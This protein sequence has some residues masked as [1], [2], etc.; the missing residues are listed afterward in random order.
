MK[1]TDPEV[2]MR[3]ER[4][5]MDGIIADLDWVLIEKIFKER[6]RLNIEDDVEYQQGNMIVHDNTIAYEL[7][8]QVKLNL[9]ILC[10]R[11]GNYIDVKSS[12]DIPEE[13]RPEN[14]TD[15]AKSD[16][17]PAPSDAMEQKIS[18]SVTDEDADEMIM[19]VTDTVPEQK[20]TPESELTEPDTPEDDSEIIDAEP[21]TPED[22][23]EITDAEPE[24]PEDD[25]EITDAEPETP[26]DDSEITDAEPEV[27]D[28]EPEDVVD[29]EPEVEID[30][31][32]SAKQLSDET[33]AIESQ[34]KVDEIKPEIMALEEYT[35]EKSEEIAPASAE[36]SDE[37]TDDTE[38]SHEPD[39]PQIDESETIPEEPEESIDDDISE[40][41]IDEEI[42]EDTDQPID[43]DITDEAIDADITDEAIDADI[44]DEAIDED[45]TDEAIDEEISEDLIAEDSIDEDSIDE[46]ISEEVKDE[47]EETD[48]VSDDISESEII[49]QEEDMS[50]DE[51]IDTLPIDDTDEDN[52]VETTD[53]VGSE[54]A[55]LDAEPAE[56]EMPRH[57]EDENEEDVEI[58][59]DD[60]IFESVS[61]KAAD[62][63]ASDEKAAD[64]KAQDSK[65]HQVSGSGFADWTEALEDADIS[66]LIP[67]DA[68]PKDKITNIINQIQAIDK[69]N[70]V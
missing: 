51:I 6:H 67:A 63:K 16:D 3:G 43:A 30:T 20:D 19:D 59:Q 64:E 8:F 7:N 26:E 35:P 14:L 52:T 1:I 45:I 54:G 66:L 25:S 13:V 4:D 46:E 50:E 11:D 17:Q 40:D 12:L 56:P 21:E 36:V 48:H 27:S 41:S 65:T 44:T 53:A 55:L 39:E 18:E 15:Q 70:S 34:G 31:E 61:E 57:G 29:T 22:D 24:T 69:N 5:L 37:L 9:S 68:T 60:E 10:D 42:S 47:Q 49:A 28:T 33:K 62:E 2:I 58:D 38:I 32:P 23:S